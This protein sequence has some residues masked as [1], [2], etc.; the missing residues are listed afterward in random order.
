MGKARRG[1]TRAGERRRG[2]GPWLGTAA[3]AVMLVIGAALGWLGWQWLADPANL[4][5]RH[6][7]L[8]GELER[9]PESRIRRA[10]RPALKGFL[11][12]DLSELERAMESLPWV[13][14]VAI[15]RDW[16]DTFVARF[17]ENT[18]V[19]RWGEDAL[20]NRHGE[21]FRPPKA[22][23]PS[24]L[25]VLDGPRSQRRALIDRFL[26]YDRQLQEAD[27]DLRALRQDQRRAIRLTLDNGIQVALGRDSIAARLRRLV[28]LYP[29]LLAGRSEKVARVDLR[30][31]NGLA[32]AWRP[33][34]GG[35]GP[36]NTETE[37]L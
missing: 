18:A 3:G 2:P 11:G 26:R 6:L 30:Y 4:P 1:A 22:E 31:T 12:T 13:R 5:V 23:F 19:A 35:G 10:V 25:P 34:V 17:E 20:L 21:L 33:G 36:E 9:T 7:Y 24:G 29:S 28:R 15:R 32:V 37:G 16:P 27:V 8:E 14:S